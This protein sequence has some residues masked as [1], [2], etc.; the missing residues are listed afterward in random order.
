MILRL[1]GMLILALLGLSSPAFA[2]EQAPRPQE[3]SDELPRLGMASG[4]PQVRSAPPSIPF[5]VAPVSRE[6]VL[7]FHGYLLLPARLG[8]HRRENPTPGQAGTVL[9][10]P[11]LTPEDF[12]RF[13][14]TAVL[15]EPWVQLNLSYGNTQVVGTVIL[16]ARSLTDAMA[17]YDPVDQLGVTDAFLRFNLEDTFRTPFEVKVG[18]MTQ[19][20]GA[21]GAF[22]AGRY[23]TPLIAR[24]N[25][26]GETITAGFRLG[27]SSFVLE[28]GAGGQIGRAARSI[29]SDGWNDFADPNTGASFVSHLHAAFGY[30]GLVQF[31]AHYLTSWCADD[32]GTG[33]TLPDGRITVLGLD[34]R[35]TSG[36]FGH[37]YLGGAR[38]QATNAGTVSGII[39]VLNARGGSD[40]VREYLGPESGGTGSLTSFGAQY[41]L[42]LSRIV[43]G[44]QSRGQHPDVLVSLFGIGTVVSSN[45]SS[46]TCDSAGLDCHATYDGVLKLKAGAEATYNLSSWFGIG[47]RFDH[48]RPNNAINRMAYSVWTA[49]LLAH[50]GWLSRDE[51]ALSY[52][53]FTYGRE[54]PVRTGYPPL[55]DPT[56]NPDR[57][58]LSLAG[59]FWW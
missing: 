54:V 14:Y 39:E 57:H 46:Q 24:T 58:V 59:T 10:S 30:A 36:R 16:A 27:K 25:A 35:L 28:Q 12:R 13:Q 45:D 38:A 6:Y 23:A 53:A 19:R 43:Y 20:Y 1:K 52:S 42:S 9:H 34:A 32:E 56:A 15:P 55:D 8:L 21:M 5:G 49:R 41:D 51:V 47:G 22:D 7:D 50:T 3:L 44:E 40:L 37:L 33:G 31:S 26:I 29:V 4:E 17:I 18:G 2:D 11:P 48:V